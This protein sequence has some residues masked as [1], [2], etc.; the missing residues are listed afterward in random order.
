[1]AYSPG[2][3]RLK[4]LDYGPASYGAAFR[5]EFRMRDDGMPPVGGA[6]P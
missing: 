3:G 4:A 1:M 2:K 6:K 5:P